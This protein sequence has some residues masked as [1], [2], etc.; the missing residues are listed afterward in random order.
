MP[1]TATHAQGKVQP[2]EPVKAAHPLPG[3]GNDLPPEIINRQEREQ[4][5]SDAVRDLNEHVQSVQREL[6]FSIDENSGHTVIKVLD[7]ETKEVIRQIPGEE[8]LRFANS[9]NE[10]ADIELINAYI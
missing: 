8:A 2:I 9:L 6:Q 3:N 5:I 10:G 1:V 7:K 4:K